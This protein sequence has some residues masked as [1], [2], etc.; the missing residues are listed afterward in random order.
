MVDTI[1]LEV[2]LLRAGISKKAAAARLGISPSG[3]RNKLYNRKDFK[4]SEIHKLTEML[5]LN[6]AERSKIF[7][8]GDVK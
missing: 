4:G 7:F 2:A 5:G 1:E 6:E 3:F 8:G